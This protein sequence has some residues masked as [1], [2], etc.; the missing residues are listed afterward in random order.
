M[1]RD[2]DWKND[3]LGQARTNIYRNNQQKITSSIGYKNPLKKKIIGE[4]VTNQIIFAS[5]IFRA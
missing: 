3:G 2:E 4:Q 5:V 1:T